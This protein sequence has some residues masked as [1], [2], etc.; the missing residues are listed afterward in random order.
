M[1]RRMYIVA[2]AYPRTSTSTRTP[3]PSVNERSRE[4]RELV[5]TMMEMETGLNE[6]ANPLALGGIGEWD[7]R[8]HHR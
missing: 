7:N 1:A 8:R 6:R 3:C 4:R 2:H 5:L